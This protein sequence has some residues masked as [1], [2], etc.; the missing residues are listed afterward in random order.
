MG[1]AGGEALGAAENVS[2]RALRSILS[3]FWRSP[4]DSVDPGGFAASAGRAGA[5]LGARCSVV[6]GL[7]R[8]FGGFVSC[9]PRCVAGPKI[10]LGPVKFRRVLV[11]VA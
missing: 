1:L 2:E 7:S 6:N 11:P 3:T 5:G 4:A 10:V 9:A 8:S